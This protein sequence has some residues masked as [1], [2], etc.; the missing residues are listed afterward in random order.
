MTDERICKVI[1]A[2]PFLVP[3]LPGRVEHLKIA[4]I[5]GWVTPLSDS[6]ANGVGL[7]TFTL[8]QVERTIP[9]VRDFFAA[10]NKGF[11][12]IVGPSSTPLNLGKRLTT[13]GMSKTAEMAG[14]VLTDIRVPIPIHPA[15][16][17]REV[18]A[19]QISQ[20]SNLMAQAYGEELS[21]E[22]AKIFNEAFLLGQ[23]DIKARAYLA[24]LT[25]NDMP[26]AFGYSLYVP[27]QPIV[28]LRL[29]ATL[30][31][32]RG[33]GIYRSLIARRLADAHADG[34]KVAIMQ[35]MRNTSAPI[36]AKLGFREL[37]NLDVYEWHPQNAF[38]KDKNP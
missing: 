22:L 4:A 21:P 23:G 35:A 13:I 25:E 1:E 16:E 29:A 32:Y 15:I 37:C 24:Y 34:A 14:M 38:Q 9:Q 17:I 31:A 18:S 3:E 28:A 26:V 2:L 7:T 33:Q 11:S 12:W 19:N 36:C 8:D 5:R 10:Q 6:Q 20:A 27:Q 30:K